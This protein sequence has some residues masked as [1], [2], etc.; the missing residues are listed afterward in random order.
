M[1]IQGQGNI[2]F[3]AGVR[4]ALENSSSEVI[5]IANP[6]CHLEEGRGLPELITC[7]QQRSTHAIV[8]PLIVDRAGKIEYHAYGDWTF[9][10]TR[11][12]SRAWSR[13]VIRHAASTRI[14]KGL[15]LP[16]TF[17]VMKRDV[18][19]KLGPFDPKF[20]LYGEDRDM[21]RRARAM[22]IDLLLCREAVA[23]HEG[24]VSA[25]TVPNIV[26]RG[27]AGAA[28]EIARRKFGVI[29]S[30]LAGFDLLVT[31]RS[32]EIRNIRLAETRRFL[33][34]EKA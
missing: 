30:V 16:G 26:T 22:N 1:T 5:V 2:G 24:G 14:P 28:L 25:K 6:D 11:Y 31:S 27:Q 10:P 21:C 32:S 15:K 8:S 17:L 19:Y 18:A 3:G 20:F 23:I 7:L 33:R 34:R 13:L 4:L 9:T 12:L 29:G